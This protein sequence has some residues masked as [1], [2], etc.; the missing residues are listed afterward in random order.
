MEIDKNT[1]RITFNEDERFITGLPA[2]AS[3]AEVDRALFVA[4][5]ARGHCYG[6]FL[7]LLMCDLELLTDEKAA[8]ITLYPDRL[9]RLDQLSESLENIAAPPEN[10]LSV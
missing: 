10:T 1:G 9:R 7:T 5:R 4:K 3:I 2:V 6:T 8:T